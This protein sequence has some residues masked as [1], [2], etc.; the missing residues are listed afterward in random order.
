MGALMLIECSSWEVVVA[1]SGLMFRRVRADRA[2]QT[3]V[4]VVEL[5]LA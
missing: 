3:V 4:V 1:V 2:P 5:V